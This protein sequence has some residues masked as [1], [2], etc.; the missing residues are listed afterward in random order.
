LSCDA[1]Y[2]SH[3]C[4]V[5]ERPSLQ[6]TLPS[7][8]TVHDH[9]H[10]ISIRTSRG[11][12][13]P[14]HGRVLRP[15]SMLGESIGVLHRISAT[16]DGV[17]SWPRGGRLTIVVRVVDRRSIVVRARCAP[18]RRCFTAVGILARHTHAAQLAADH[19]TPDHDGRDA[20]FRIGKDQR[21]HLQ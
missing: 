6:R 5:G 13:P 10:R 9:L 16:N 17:R 18:P 15:T 4:A 19:E 3:Q 11:R 1:Q 12:G 21:S 8:H 2:A 14:P 20:A 7:N